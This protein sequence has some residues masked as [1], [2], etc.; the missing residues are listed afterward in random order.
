MIRDELLPESEG[1][2]GIFPA[3]QQTY[4]A[5][6]TLRNIRQILQIFEVLQMEKFYSSNKYRDVSR[7]KASVYHVY[8]SGNIADFAGAHRK[9]SEKS[10]P[11]KGCLK[12]F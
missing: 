7:V 6:A 1:Q 12:N 9:P 5:Q 11:G 10:H 8:F 3:D 4:Y 2:S